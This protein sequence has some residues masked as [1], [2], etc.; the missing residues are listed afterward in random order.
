MNSQQ[1]LSTYEAVSELTGHMLAAAQVRDW[2]NLA[3]LESHCANHVQRLKD[4]EGAITLSGEP[5]ARKIAIIHEIM[6]HDREI[7]NLTEPWMAQLAAMMQ[8]TGTE[9]KLARA[10]GAN[11]A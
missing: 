5:R 9:R 4:S 10:Y 1:I 7:R 8:S 2:E 11:P 3:L 6:A